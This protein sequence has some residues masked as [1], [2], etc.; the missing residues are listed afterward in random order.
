MEAPVK[1]VGRAKSMLNVDNPALAGETA[2]SRTVWEN[3]S[4]PRG[5]LG[6]LDD[7]SQIFTVIPVH[8]RAQPRLFSLC[9]PDVAHKR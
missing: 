3:G 2:H 8:L 5:F 7:Y 9:N 1:P 4:N 6:C